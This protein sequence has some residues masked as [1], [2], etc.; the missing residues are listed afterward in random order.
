MGDEPVFDSQYHGTVYNVFYSSDPN[1]KSNTKTHVITSPECFELISA[2]WRH[3]IQQFPV[4]SL[5]HVESKKM[6]VTVFFRGGTPPIFLNTKPEPCDSL[7]RALTIVTGS[8]KPETKSLSLSGVL[9]SFRLEEK[10]RTFQLHRLITDQTVEL[11][12]TFRVSTEAPA[13]CMPLVD[14]FTCLFRFRYRNDP[15]IT[16]DEAVR[17]LGADVRRHLLIAW[18]YAIINCAQPLNVPTAKVYF[19]RLALHCSRTVELAAKT[20]NIPCDGLVAACQTYAQDD[21]VNGI[22]QLSLEIARQAQ[23]GIDDGIAAIA[24]CD[25]QNLRVLL[26]LTV[27]VLAAAISGMYVVDLE[28][29]AS[30]IVEYTKAVI[31]RTNI[32]HARRVLF[33]VQQA[34]LKDMLYFLD[35]QR[36]EEPFQYLFCTW[37]FGTLDDNE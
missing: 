17:N 8:P 22:E 9:P 12:Q 5:D 20:L 2:D 29:I 27:L 19:S 35:G 6:L 21:I 26:N 36:Y 4:G 16:F 10:N 18:S 32:D 15:T 31:M 30:K 14:V 37:G 3:S 1:A 13:V 28:L 23:Q 7:I 33:R 24:P 34:F 25:V 11:L